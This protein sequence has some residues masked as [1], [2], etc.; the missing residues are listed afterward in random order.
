[1]KRPRRIG[2]TELY[3]RLFALRAGS[4]GGCVTGSLG[5]ESVYVTGIVMSLCREL[6]RVCD[7]GPAAG[8]CLRD[9]DSDVFVPGAVAGV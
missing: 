4:C 1:M 3:R 7:R 6:W 5:R 8:V 9:R 2:G